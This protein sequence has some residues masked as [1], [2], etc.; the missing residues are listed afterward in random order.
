MLKRLPRFVKNIL[1][2]IDKILFY[3][4]YTG[5]DEYHKLLEKEV[6]DCDS[7]LDLACGHYSPVS[8]YIT[9]MKY[10]LGVDA[11]EP[12]IETA[13]TLMSHKENKVMDILK[14]DKA[15]K[16]NTFDCVIALD[17]IEH[18]TPI[19][20]EKLIK[21]MESIAKKRV[22]IFTPNG[23]VHQGEY[24]NNPYQVHKSGWS[25]SEMRKRG[26]RVYGLNGFKFLRG[27]YAKTKFK[28]SWFWERISY[29]TQYIV[30]IFP[31]TSYQIF[32]VKDL[33]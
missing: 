2:G 27:E 13:K 7:L 22:I 6:K 30:K 14:V 10:S 31:S 33:D 1:I 15:I 32:C 26:Y 25:Y 8:K 3:K 12:A 21:D 19:E 20:G 5:Y 11:F 24:D 28:P 4:F 9:H 18:L 23:F 16:P 17:L 29:L